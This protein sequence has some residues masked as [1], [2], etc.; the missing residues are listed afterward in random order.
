MGRERVSLGCVSRSVA[1]RSRCA[2]FVVALGVVFVSVLGVAEVAL[3]AGGPCPNA[4]FRV[5][6]SASLPDCRAYEFVTPAD[7]GRTQALT[8]TGGGTKAAASGDG[9]AVAL[10]TIAPLEPSATTPASIGGARVVLAQLQGRM[11]DEV[12]RGTRWERG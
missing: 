9:E 8:F 5:G 7:L 3:A 4:E 6:R 2:R 10:Y 1:C 11:G 12:G